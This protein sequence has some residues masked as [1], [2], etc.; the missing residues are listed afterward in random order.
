MAA[1]HCRT[2]LAAP[3]SGSEHSGNLGGGILRGGKPGDR[4]THP[5]AK[6]RS[7]RHTVMH[8]H[9]RRSAG[10]RTCGRFPWGIPSG[11]RFPELLPVLDDGVRFHLPLR[12][13][14][15]FSPASLLRRRALASALERRTDGRDDWDERGARQG[16]SRMARDA[17]HV[18]CR[19]H[20][21]NAGSK[22]P[23]PTA[24]ASHRTCMFSFLLCFT[25][26]SCFWEVERGSRGR[27]G[28]AFPSFSPPGRRAFRLPLLRPQ[29]GEG[30]GAGDRPHSEHKA[31]CGD[32]SRLP[33]TCSAR[34]PDTITGAVQHPGFRK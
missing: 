20:R 12:G 11:R 32:G 25:P 33:L 9:H 24:A 13:S 21:R 4:P 14:A 6:A 8:R 19:T 29:E 31:R 30:G 7:Q 34:R 5:P 28:G 23:A 2:D 1:A 3:A 10:L 15:G 16:E 27:G 26:F 17:F 18:E 22:L